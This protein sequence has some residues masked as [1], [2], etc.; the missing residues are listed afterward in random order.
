MAI[1]NPFDLPEIREALAPFLSRDDLTRCIRVCK[2]WH[3]SF[4]LFLWTSVVFRSEQN[5]QPPLEN[6]S[7]HRT[8]VRH[9][10]FHRYIPNDYCSIN[11]PTLR[12]LSFRDVKD[13]TAINSI[14]RHHPSISQLE[15]HLGDTQWGSIWIIPNEVSNLSTLRLIG[16]T[17]SS[18]GRFWRIFS[19]LETLEL[20]SVA[21]PP[22]RSPET[23][24]KVKELTMSSMT[25]MAASSQLEMIKRCPELRRLHWGQAVGIVSLDDFARSM[26]TWPLLEDL[27]LDRSDASD[28]QLSIIIGK[29]R[30][31]IRLSVFGTQF[32]IQAMSALR[33]HFHSLRRL[34]MAC[35]KGGMDDATSSEFSIEV[36][37]SCP[38]LEHLKARGV[39]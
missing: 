5:R 17:L 34:N 18:M 14:I 21:L 25:W 12:T 13:I 24:W 9:L 16:M 33:N 11:C 28:Q 35:S 2:A 6:L 26:D 1:T 27:C 30:R 37:K 4:Y 20:Q 36:L 8:L 38:Q 29:M 23:P 7:R 10:E 19:Q 32:N 39:S 3:Y 22:I 31:V 15:L